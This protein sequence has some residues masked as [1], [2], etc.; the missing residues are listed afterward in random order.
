[1]T[2]RAVNEVLAVVVRQR[3]ATAHIRS[4]NGPEFIAK[5]IRA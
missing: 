3:G 1:M 4:D 5:A 2:A